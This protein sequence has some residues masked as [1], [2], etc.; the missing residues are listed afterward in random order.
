M[1]QARLCRRNRSSGGTPPTI[2]H[3]ARDV[4][5]LLPKNSSSIAGSDEAGMQRAGCF[6]IRDGPS[7]VFPIRA[8]WTCAGRQGHRGTCRVAGQPRHALPD[9]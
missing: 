9:Q 3:T 2:H 7:T 6:A 5:L 1:R 8:P 4:S